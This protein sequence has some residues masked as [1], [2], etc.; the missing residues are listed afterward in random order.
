MPVDLGAS[1]SLDLPEP[2]PHRRQCDLGVRPSWTAGM[3]DWNRLQRRKHVNAET[4]CQ[5]MSD[6]TGTEPWPGRHGP[7]TGEEPGL[8]DR[9]WLQR[10]TELPTHERPYG[11][12]ARVTWGYAPSYVQS[13][14]RRSATPPEGV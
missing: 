8:L 2:V 9:T 14:W 13:A 1:A 12:S 5:N 3:V 6:W 7:S 4:V 10:F 11:I